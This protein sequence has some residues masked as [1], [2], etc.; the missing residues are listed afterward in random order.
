MNYLK[1][2]GDYAKLKSMGYRFQKLYANNYMSWSKNGVFIFKKG[3]DITHGEIDLYKL[4]EFLRSNPNTKS[5]GGPGSVSFLA[6]YNDDKTCEYRDYSEENNRL[7]IANGKEW[8]QYNPDTDETPQ[9]IYPKTAGSELIEQL[10]ELDRL[11]WYELASTE[12]P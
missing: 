8:L 7:Y 6:F 11:G 3:A 1:F 2:T 9:Q 10:E 5:Y 12:T 4:V